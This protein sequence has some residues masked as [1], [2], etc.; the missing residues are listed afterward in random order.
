MALF[1][2][3]LPHEN[4]VVVASIKEKFSNDNYFEINSTQLIV[5]GKG[6]AQRISDMIGI[7]SED[8]KS[9]G[10]AVVLA[11]SGYWGRASTDLWEWMR[12][13]IE[14]RDNG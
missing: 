12:V 8:E 7:T 11:F 3:L 5:S 14:E 6:S 10:S 1:V 13:K 2:V 9:I 4:P